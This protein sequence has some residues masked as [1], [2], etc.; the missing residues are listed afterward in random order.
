MRKVKMAIKATLFACGLAGGFAFAEDAKSAAKPDVGGYDIFILMGQSNADGRGSSK[1]VPPELA[2]PSK[3]HIIFYHN[4]CATTP[5]WEA[6]AP[7]Y[8]TGKKP[9]TVPK[10]GFGIEVSFAPALAEEMPGMKVAIIKSAL[11]STDIGFKWNAQT[12]A[13]GEK[14][15]RPGPCYRTALDAINMAIAKL[16]A[17][18]HRLRG[19]LWHQG[20]SDA[21]DRSYDKKLVHLITRLREDLKAPELPFVFGGLR[22]GVGS[23]WN[24][25]AAQATT[26]TPNLAFVS[27]DGL[28]GDSLHFNSAALIEFG[29]R[30]AKATLPLLKQAKPTLIEGGTKNYTLRDPAIYGPID[31]RNDAANAA[32]AAEKAKKGK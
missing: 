17:G 29:K 18:Q 12:D 9:T 10:G 32:K 15:Q 13:N 24:V 28:E 8:S 21:G 16:P 31:A 3:D 4:G 1:D 20:E 30:Y 6:L 5:D 11:G 25:V 23:K 27:S 2:Q 26:L 14:A 7:G 19:M 22:P